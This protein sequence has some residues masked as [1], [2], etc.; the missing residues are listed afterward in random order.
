VTAG[1]GH[2][3]IRSFA[4][5]HIDDAARLLADRHRTQR[6]AEPALDP[7]FEDPAPARAEIEALAARDGADGAVALRGGTVVGYVVAAPRGDPW[8]PNMWIEGAG[9]AVA[10]P[11]VVRDLYGALAGAWVEGGAIRHSVI[12]PASNAA[13]VD[14]WFRVGFGLQHAHG[15][16]E[17]A[18][19]DESLLPP[20]GMT[21]RRAERRDIPVLGRLGRALADHQVAS[22]VFSMLGMPPLEDDTA[23]WE[24]GFDDQALTTFVAEVDGTV[25][26]SAVG[27]SIDESSEHRGIVRPPNAGFLGFAAVLPEARGLGAG[28][29]LAEAVLV[30]A[31]DAGHPSV[32][33]DWRVTNLLSS[34]TW[35]RLGFRT[36]FLR[37]HRAIA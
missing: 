12:V 10:D 14:A 17:P 15:I 4:A 8:G 32:V 36:V 16:R 1:R 5:E 18:A 28:R 26:G 23:E 30:W 21:V 13:L 29:A 11:E 35:P 22:P 3:E 6:L 7:R 9:H 2:L 34:R 20:V 33:T 25:I 27:C 19:P 37:L 24:E 31:R